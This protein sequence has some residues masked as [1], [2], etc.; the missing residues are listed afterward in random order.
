[1]SQGDALFDAIL[2]GHSGVVFARDD[3]DSIWPRLGNDGKVRLDL[4]DMLA[5]LPTL[6]QS[7]TGTN[8][9]YPFVLMA[10][11][12]RDYTAN[13]IY[14][15]GGWRRKDPEGALRISPEDAERLGLASGGNASITTRTGK[16]T[17]TVEVT[18]RMQPGHVSLPP[19]GRHRP[20]FFSALSSALRASG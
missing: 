14:R 20:S 9:D 13:T 8:E 6:S 18:D 12:R 19:A 11:E 17:A 2:A 3:Y 10:G 16:A 7:P 1:M 5:L 4:P 15:H